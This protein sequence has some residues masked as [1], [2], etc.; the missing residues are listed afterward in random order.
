M[1]F[2]SFTLKYFISLRETYVILVFPMRI[3]GNAYLF[4]LIGPSDLIPE[5]VSDV[6]SHMFLVKTHDPTIFE[7]NMLFFWKT[8]MC[9]PSLDNE[10]YK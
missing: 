6:A 3:L 10:H 4:N 9:N 7:K 2:H 8:M 1:G 5:W